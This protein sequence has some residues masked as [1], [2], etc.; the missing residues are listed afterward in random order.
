MLFFYRFK[1]GYYET[2]YGSVSPMAI[3]KSLNVFVK[4]RNEYLRAVESKEY[5]D[6]QKAER[7]GAISYAEYLKR[8]NNQV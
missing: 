5:L 1:L 7:K 8:K 3:T 6:K 4:E 2:F